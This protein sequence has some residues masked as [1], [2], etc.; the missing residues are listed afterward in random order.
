MASVT[1]IRAGI[2]H[3]A[4]CEVN[5]GDHPFVQHPSYI[6]YRYSRI[7]PLD[8]VAHMVSTGVWSPHS[9]CTPELLNRI[10]AG[11]CLSRLSSRE[12]KQIL[13]C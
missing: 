9:Q 6:A 13:G 11:A 10:R 1:S 4:A 7:D 8:H 2:P 3:D 12:F 5:T